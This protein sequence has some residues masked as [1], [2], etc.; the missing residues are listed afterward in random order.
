MSATQSRSGPS[1]WKRRSTRSMALEAFGSGVVVITKRR[2]VTPRNPAERISR[3][4]RLRP[5]RIPWSSA[6]SAWIMG[7]PYAPRERRWI[8]SILPVSHRS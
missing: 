7:E 5:I 4:T 6:S 8:A 2:N 3:A 1:A